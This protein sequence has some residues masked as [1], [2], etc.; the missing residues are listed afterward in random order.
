M[1]TDIDFIIKGESELVLTDLANKIKDKKNDY[2]D[3]LGIGYL[4]QDNNYCETA[5]QEIISRK[6]T[7]I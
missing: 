5:N 4:N 6:S 1:M 2:K 3:I 7:L